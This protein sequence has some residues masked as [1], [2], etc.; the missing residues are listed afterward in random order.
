MSND[1]KYTELRRVLS[2]AADQAEFGKG[3]E[4]HANDN[5]FQDQQICQ[6]PLWQ[7]T[8]DGLVFQVC[9]KALE[10]KRLSKEAAIKELRGSAVYLGAALI[11]RE[12][13]P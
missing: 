2:E 4:R 5:A 6:I 9:K 1:S 11:V 12:K 10:A 3:K 8:I 13:L 7:Q